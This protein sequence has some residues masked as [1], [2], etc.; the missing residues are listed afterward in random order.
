MSDQAIVPSSYS[1]HLRPAGSEITGSQHKAVSTEACDAIWYHCGGTSALLYQ[2]SCFFVMSQVICSLMNHLRVGIRAEMGFAQD[3]Q[4]PTFSPLRTCLTHRARQDSGQHTDREVLYIS[5]HLSELDIP[6]P[7][8][9]PGLGVLL[10]PREPT[11]LPSSVPAR[12]CQKLS[13]GPPLGGKG[14][15][16]G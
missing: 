6:G 7:N 5:M 10:P 9:S 13:S 1:Y 2:I 8:P 12:A 15:G 11:L 4:K 14:G 3:N 16:T